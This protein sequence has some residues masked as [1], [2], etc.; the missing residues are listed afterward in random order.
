MAEEL[1]QVV[2]FQ[3]YQKNLQDKWNQT[4]LLH[5]YPN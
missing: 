5:I 1:R 4:N 3:D 2:Y